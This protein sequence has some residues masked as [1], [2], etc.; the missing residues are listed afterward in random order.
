MTQDFKIYKSQSIKML[1]P[2]EQASSKYERF[3]TQPRKSVWDKLTK[4]EFLSKKKVSRDEIITFTRELAT[5]LESGVPISK[6][7]DLLAAQR[8]GEPMGPIATQ[9]SQDLIGGATL[10]EAFGR[11][12]EVFSEGYI[13]S[14]MSASRGAPVAQSLYKAADF[15]SE[16]ANIMGEMRRQLTYPAL[17]VVIGMVIVTILLTVS[18]PQMINLFSNLDSELPVPTRILIAISNA[19]R[20]YPEYIA[21]SL[22]IASLGTFRFVKSSRGRRFVHKAVLYVPMLNKIILFNDISRFSDVSSSLLESG[23]QLP[24]T[25]EVAQD[26]V[27][28]DIIREVLRGVSKAAEMGEGIAQPMKRSGVFPGTFTQSLEVAEN[29]GTLAETLQR[30]SVLYRDDASL[31]IKSMVGMVQP[32]STIFVAVIVGFIAISVIMPMYTA[33]GQFD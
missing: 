28:N 18:L 27:G 33:L 14:I 7:L 29:T 21:L 26:S 13:R 2:D 15:M 32:M 1:E 8:E 31:K 4:T 11:H 6:S 19:I 22:L 20:G 23:M 9:I 10:V 30:L 5:M 16:R 12:T 17:V 3:V 24:A 25:L